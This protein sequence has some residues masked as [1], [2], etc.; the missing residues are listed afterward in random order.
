M[1]VCNI[2]GS[3]CCRHNGA[4]ASPAILSGTRESW[5][6]LRIAQAQAMVDVRLAGPKPAYGSPGELI[7]LVVF[8]DVSQSCEGS[9]LSGDPFPGRRQ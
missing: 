1:L 6:L 5:V 4:A 8:A 2:Y 7:P 9:G 3:I